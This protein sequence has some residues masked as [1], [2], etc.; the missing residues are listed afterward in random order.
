MATAKGKR[1][2]IDSIKKDLPVLRA[3]AS[4]SARWIATCITEVLQRSA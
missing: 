3:T 2:E 1:D 4:K